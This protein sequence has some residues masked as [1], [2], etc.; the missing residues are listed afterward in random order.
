[1]AKFSIIKNKMRELITKLH[2]NCLVPLFSC[3]IS[4]DLAFF[5]CTRNRS[6]AT[7]TF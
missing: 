5:L 3:S 1:M 2:Y 6:G 4:A 7:L